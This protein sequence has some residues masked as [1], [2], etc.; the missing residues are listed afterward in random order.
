M[1]YVYIYMQHFILHIIQF[2]LIRG[3]KMSYKCSLKI[4]ISSGTYYYVI[5]FTSN[6]KY[7]VIFL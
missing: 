1:L 5:Y 6:M 2:L 3:K 4:K 7:C